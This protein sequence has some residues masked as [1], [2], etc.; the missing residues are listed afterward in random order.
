[1]LSFKVDQIGHVYVATYSDSLQV[2]RSNPSGGEIFRTRSDQPR[3]FYTE[4]TGSFPGISWPGRGVDHPPQLA[5]RLKK[6]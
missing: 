5:L 4:G 6:E 3:V 1:M 2:G